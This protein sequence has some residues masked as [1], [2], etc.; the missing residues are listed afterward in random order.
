VP[1]DQDDP[2]SGAQF[3]TV[4]PQNLPKTT[5]DAVAIHRPGT[6]APRRDKAD[7]RRSVWVVSR[8][9]HEHA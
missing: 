2:A 3:G 8:C 1:R 5:A 7:A 9:A 6:D 4:P